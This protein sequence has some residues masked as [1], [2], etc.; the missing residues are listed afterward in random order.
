MKVIVAGDGKVGL[1]LTRQLLREGHE[2][3]TI[4][5]NPQV[6]HLNLE[7]YD[8]MTVEGN[9]AALDTLRQAGAETAELLIAA[10]S[11]DETNILCCLTARILNPKIHTIARVRNPEYK[12]Q[13]FQMYRQLGLSMSINPELLAAR[14]IF[15]LLQFPSFLR[16]ETFASGRVEIVELK[17]FPDSRLAGIA[18][19]DLYKIVRVKVLVCAVSRGGRVEIPDGSY[20]LQPGDHIYVTA[21]SATLSQLL[22][23]LGIGTQSARRAILVGGSRICFYLAQQLLRAGLQVK[24]VE[25][26]PQ[27]ASCLAEMLPKADVVLGDGSSREVLES[28]GIRSA[29]AVVTLTDMDEENIVI[30]MYSSAAQVPKVVTKVNRLEYSSMFAEMGIGTVISPKDLCSNVVVRY[31]RA[32]QNQKGSVL[33]LHRIADGGA[34]ALEFRVDDTVPWRGTPLRDVPLKKGFL[35]SCITR[36]G[37][38][39]IPDGSTCFETDDTAVVVATSEEPILRMKDIFEE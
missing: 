10:T 21:R 4:D 30:S 38:T 23:N 3:V 27:R 20:V 13:L 32:M 19:S 11:A 17:V 12:E 7:Q 33:T 29:D 34:E 39:I 5:S 37:E 2:L 24:I 25:K 18:L 31:V 36:R 8:V 26:D 1:A 9:A 16:R 14:E 6:L 15:R 35:I 28:E 22:R